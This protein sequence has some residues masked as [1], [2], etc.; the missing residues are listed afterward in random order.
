MQDAL[1]RLDPSLPVCWEDL[2]T[3]RIGFEHAIVRIQAPSAGA[4]RF[5][6][7]L[8]Q[9]LPAR[10]PQQELRRL[11]I[12][13]AECHRLRELLRPALISSATE[14][15]PS[16]ASATTPDPSTNVC[17]VGPGPAPRTLATLLSHAGVHA[18]SAADA[19][20][21]FTPRGAA[22][23]VAVVTQ[24]FFEPV[25][26][27]LTLLTETLPQLRVRFTDRS[28]WV[29]PFQTPGSSP[30]PGCA[31]EHALDA[32]PALPVLTGQL[33]GHIPATEHTDVFLAVASLVA[34]VIKTPARSS[35]LY[36]LTVRRGTPEPAPHTHLLRQ[37]PRCQCAQSSRATQAHEALTS[38]PHTH[39]GVQYLTQQ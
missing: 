12:S 7:A 3:L 21:L 6:G 23:S 34:S 11:G 29:G 20:A 18:S 32:D 28:V 25:D 26:R 8:R 31:I 15:R 14:A 38:G 13:P 33:V 24:R 39:A 1:L 37:H 2:T 16:A 5:I 4:Q 30:C 9:G 22:T 35:H 36:Q 10:M 17:V 19:T 27:R